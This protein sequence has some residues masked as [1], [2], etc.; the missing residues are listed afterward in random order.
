M[1]LRLIR[2]SLG[3]LEQQTIPKLAHK[4]KFSLLGVLVFQN[5]EQ[6]KVNKNMTHKS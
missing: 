2:N 4:L 5:E 3:G 1:T 6:S